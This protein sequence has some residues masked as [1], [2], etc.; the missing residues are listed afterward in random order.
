M[1]KNPRIIVEHRE[2][3][4]AQSEINDYLLEDFLAMTAKQR[5]KVGV[6]ASPEWEHL[7]KWARSILPYSENC[8]IE[9]TWEDGRYIGLQLAD[10]YEPEI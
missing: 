3:A 4:A 5:E 8:V 7:V 2:N 1:N 10:E 9:I 6:T